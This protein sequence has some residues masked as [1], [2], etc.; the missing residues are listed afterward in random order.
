[1]ARQPDGDERFLLAHCTGDQRKK[2]FIKELAQYL[3]HPRA[4]IMRFARRT[5]LLHYVSLGSSHNA[6]PY[7]T[8]YGAQRII[9]YCRV[10]QGALYVRGRDFHKLLERERA[11]DA[12]YWARKRAKRAIEADAQANRLALM[13]AVVVAEPDGERVGDGGEGGGL[14]LALEQRAPGRGAE[15]R[16]DGQAPRGGGWALALLE[17]LRHQ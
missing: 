2:V 11:E 5:G 3:G 15:L 8:E 1:M 14:P 7:V 6:E 12:R 4:Q 16:E 10:V 17:V 9:A 13:A